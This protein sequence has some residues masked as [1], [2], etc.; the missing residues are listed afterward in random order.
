MNNEITQPMPRGFYSEIKHI[1]TDA[2]SRAYRAVNTA[3][4]QAYWHVGRLIVEAQGG[5]ERA[6]YGE[7]LI[8]ELSHRLT[9]DF[10][11]GFTA[12]NLRNMRQFYLSFPKCDA[13]R[14]ELSWTHYRQL[15]RVTNPKARAYYAEEAAKAPWSV[16]QLERQ[17]CTQYYERLLAHHKDES[18][19]E[20]LIQA[21]LPA[22]PEKFDPLKLVHD[23]FV[24][25]FLGVKD[26]PS[27]QEK[28]LETAI[29]SHLSEFLLELGRGFAFV[30]RQK[31]ITIDGNHFYP[32]LVFYNTIAKCYVIIDLKMGKAGY[33]EVGQM[34][35]YVNYY[36]REICTDTDNP[37][38]GIV[39]CA[40][41]NDAEVKYT[42]GNRNDI[43]VFSPSYHLTMPT[44]EEL[45]REIEITREN[46]KLLHGTEE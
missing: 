25:E 23:P 35:L 8:K 43:S 7:G 16:R 14:S 33:A 32:D 24:L 17:I 41:K 29:I 44:E 21:N 15:M 38:V 45:R 27:L 4:V 36:N 10:G 30:G 19:V 28:D 13:L 37:T 22:K 1:L 6:A 31:R 39:L 12:A 11:K 20:E 42:L 26:D 18:E 40:K 9:A 3:M 2:R 34:Q 46:F 5:E